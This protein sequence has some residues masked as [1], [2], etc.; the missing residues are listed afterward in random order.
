VPAVI[1]VR[2]GDCAGDLTFHF[3]A[4]DVGTKGSL[5]ERFRLSLSAQ[6]A[7]RT[8][9]DGCMGVNA[10]PPSS[11]SRACAKVRFTQAASEAVVLPL[12]FHN[13]ASPSPW[14]AT[15]VASF[16]SRGPEVASMATPRVSIT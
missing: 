6:R 2:Q 3:Q 8:G 5:P 11:K 15:S 14:P 12:P 4:D 13:I 7:A 16:S 9:E 1:V 10:T